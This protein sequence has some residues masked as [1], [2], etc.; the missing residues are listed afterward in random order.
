M[1]RKKGSEK[2]KVKRKKSKSKG[3]R[4]GVEYSLLSVQ[5]LSPKGRATQFLQPVR[6][7]TLAQLLGALGYSRP[8]RVPHFTGRQ[9]LDC[10]SS[11]PHHHHLS[12]APTYM[13]SQSS[14]G[15]YCKHGLTIDSYRVVYVPIYSA[16]RSS[17]SRDGLSCT[18]TFGISVGRWRVM[19]CDGT[20]PCL[21]L[22]EVAAFV[23]RTSKHTLTG[24]CGWLYRMYHPCPHQKG[25]LPKFIAYLALP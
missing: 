19:S 21:F 4:K 13:Y 25:G 17:C 5:P 7:R 18:S 15:R 9:Y 11:R 8:Q 12:C 20:C 1:Q 23:L 2:D 24:I 6:H 22:A 3:K 16:F 10:P 14:G